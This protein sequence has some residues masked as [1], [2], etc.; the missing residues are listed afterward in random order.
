M[1]TVQSSRVVNETGALL[2]GWPD[3]CVSLCVSYRAPT[4]LDAKCG[5]AKPGRVTKLVL[6]ILACPAEGRLVVLFRQCRT[7]ARNGAKR[8]TTPPSARRLR[9]CPVSCART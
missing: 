8:S 1:H 4:L 9:R 3:V 6:T 7:L 5:S 2:D